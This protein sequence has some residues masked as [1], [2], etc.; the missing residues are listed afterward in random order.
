MF[1]VVNRYE[2]QITQI[3]LLDNFGGVKSVSA[4][5]YYDAQLQQSKGQGQEAMSAG[6]SGGSRSS[7][8]SSG[9]VSDSESESEAEQGSG[10]NVSFA[11]IWGAAFLGTVCGVL[12]LA[13]AALGV[14]VY[15]E[16]SERNQY[17]IALSNADV[18]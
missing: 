17:S 10:G 8:E 16:K 13:A 5:D 2:L 12:L 15:M 14:K 6:S 9:A 11:G 7:S 1:C 3:H 4:K 18:K